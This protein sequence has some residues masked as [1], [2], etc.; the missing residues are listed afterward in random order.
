MK[1]TTHLGAGAVCGIAIATYAALPPE[2]AIVA[3]SCAMVASV[4][5]DVDSATSIIGRVFLPVSW[6]TNQ[7]FG[8]RTVFHALLPW[9]LIQGIAWL[10]MPQYPWY[11]LA[12]GAGV[13]SHLILD[14]FNPTGIPLLWPIKVKFSLG[15]CRSGGMIDKLLGRIFPAVAGFLL[16][17]YLCQLWL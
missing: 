14:I 13:L 1:G 5:P 2:Q 10:A 7:L 9:S 3:T 6:L 4:L 11:L 15:L 8:H 17:S 16:V 12:L